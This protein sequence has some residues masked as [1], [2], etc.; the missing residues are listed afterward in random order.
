MSK[1]SGLESAQR[2][3]LVRLGELTPLTNKPAELFCAP[4]QRA[5]LADVTPFLATGCDRRPRR[6][7]FRSIYHRRAAKSSLSTAL[8]DSLGPPA[9]LFNEHVRPEPSIR[10]IRDRCRSWRNVT[11]A[12]A[13]GRLS[14]SQHRLA[15]SQVRA[16]LPLAVL[17]GRQR[18]IER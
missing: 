4:I 18:D 9:G 1:V 8:S 7:A 6:P 13:I 14:D 10:P 11:S 5:Q 2:L 12:T 17:D 16:N 15:G 3:K